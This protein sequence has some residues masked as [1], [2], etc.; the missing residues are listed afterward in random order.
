MTTA[1]RRFSLAA[2]LAA[3]LLACLLAG[4]VAAGAA[5]AAP[6]G[7]IDIGTVD[8]HT[9]LSAL[10]RDVKAAGQLRAKLVRVEFPWSAFEPNR[11]GKLDSAAVKAAD[12]LVKDAAAAHVKIVAL[13]ESTPCWATSA[14]PKLRSGCKLGS[15]GVA[16]AWPPRKASDYGAFV[17]WLAKRYGRQLAAIE[18]WN[19]PDQINQDYLRGKNKPLE[20][21]KLLRAA[22]PAIKH[23]DRHVKVL[24]GSLVGSNGVFM[25]D[26]YKDG[27][28][29]YYDGVAV[30][31]Y[32]LTLGALHYFHHVQ[33]KNHDHK[34]LWLDEVGW[35][36]CWP[37]YKIEQEQGCVTKQVQARN[38]E[39]LFHQL[40]RTRYVAAILPYTLQD[41]FKEE[42]GV[43]SASG[44]RKPSFHALSK[45]LRSPFGRPSPV[46]LSLKAGHGRVVASGSGPVGD[47]M[48]LEAFEHGALRYHALFTLNR[49][50][51]YSI[52][53]PR[54]LGTHGLRVRVYQYWLGRK[55]DAQRSI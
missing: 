40:A 51:R 7:G 24:A 14:P 48:K 4:A 44:A 5:Q 9:S 12:R 46:K 29:G 55:A 30:H 45:V 52:K 38:L 41:G 27:I 18:V 32:T 36:S 49:F 31:F 35:S 11:R 3:T 8:G 19:E 16:N 42:F 2:T 20:Y 53:L 13:T 47:Y 26:L 6:I 28:K 33:V 15:G 22:Y 10:D 43:L 21:A 17:G 50:N 37:R 25:E 23:A 34:P 39:D 54:A 1:R